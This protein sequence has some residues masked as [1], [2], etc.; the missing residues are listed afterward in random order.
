MIP[1]T[2]DYPTDL[3]PGPAVPERKRARHHRDWEFFRAEALPPREK[4]WPFPEAFPGVC[5]DD[6]PRFLLDHVNTIAEGEYQVVDLFLSPINYGLGIM[7][8]VG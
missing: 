3:I 6:G 1:G 4:P 5:G 7:R 2:L 8:R